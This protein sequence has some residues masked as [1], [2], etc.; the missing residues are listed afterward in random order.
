MRAHT[1]PLAAAVTIALT[2]AAVLAACS[3][4][5]APAPGPGSSSGGV[6]AAAPTPDAS[7]TGDGAAAGDAAPTDGAT[8]DAAV[9]KAKNCTG[10]FGT[11]LTNAFGRLD[12]KVLAIVQPKDQQCPRP[13]NDHVILEVT[14]Q[15]AAY[16]VVINV[17]S[18]RPDPDVRLRYAELPHA[19]P[20]DA[21]ADGWHPGVSF[22]Y[23]DT[24]GVH[25]TDAMFTPYDLAPLSQKIADAMELGDEVAVY[26][27]SS[28]GDSAHLVHRNKPGQDG[29]IVVRPRSATPKIMLFH[30][31]T[32]SF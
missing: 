29:A 2:L 31:A 8:S 28:G 32:Q 6:D 21:W 1:A 5:P 19:L 9:D 11:A 14:S 22:D 4:D 13:N 7:S 3:S 17:Q 15:G 26:T 10:T 25:S 24:L 30:F 16:R 12:G 27:T 20:G 23:V 18:D